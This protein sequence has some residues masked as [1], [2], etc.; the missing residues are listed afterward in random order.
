MPFKLE[1]LAANTGYNPI[2][3]HRHGYYEL[4][5]FLTGSG[6]HMIDF[7]EWQIVPGHF[8]FLSPGQIHYI[9][10]TPETTGWVLKFAPEFIQNQ[11]EGGQLLTR[12]P[13]MQSGRQPIIKPNKDDFDDLLVWV[14]QI[15]QEVEKR[16]VGFNQLIYHYLKILLLKCHRLYDYSQSMDLSS[17]SRNFQ[18]L[19]EK[20]YLSR[21]PVSFYC[22]QLHV[23]DDKLNQELKRD[24]GQPAVTLM[25][26]RLLLEAKR[27]LLHSD[28]SIKE[29]AYGLQFKDNAYF[30]R[31]FKKWAS[32]SPGEFREQNRKK[33]HSKQK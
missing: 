29:I 31:W 21:Q 7:Q 28:Q 8:H 18:V 14:D 22:E 20:H 27:L 11:E 9:R 2:A 25:A 26:R 4:F 16:G 32:C 23:S 5:L 3:P 6:L 24:F 19:L 1:R 12:I 10:R 15:K 17:T 13:F 30:T 33:Y